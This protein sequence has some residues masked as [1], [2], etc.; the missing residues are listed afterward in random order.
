ATAAAT[1][2]QRQEPAA[3]TDWIDT[4]PQVRNRH[5]QDSEHFTGKQT[6]DGRHP[7]KHR[8]LEKLQPTPQAVVQQILDAKMELPVKTVL[9]NIS[10]AK[11][12]FFVAGSKK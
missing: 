2:I 7:K 12:Q 4:V 1:A 10:D 3:K 11:K 9:K 6:E 8:L 5:E